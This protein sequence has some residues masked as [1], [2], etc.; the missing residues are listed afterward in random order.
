MKITSVR[1]HKLESG[2]GFNNYAVAA[3][4]AVEDGDDPEQVRKNLSMWV[5][6][7]IRHK[8]E[9]AKLNDDL[10]WLREQCVSAERERDALQHQ[11]DA[12]RAIITSHEELC[13]LAKERGIQTG[14]LDDGELPF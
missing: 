9:C 13:R 5:E 3:E 8:V 11:V 1:V 6:M 4:A 12:N 2:P 7:Q 10:Q 14:D